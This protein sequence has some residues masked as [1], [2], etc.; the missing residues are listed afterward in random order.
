MLY[1]SLDAR[2]ID[3]QNTI[4]RAILLNLQY[5]NTSTPEEKQIYKDL[6]TNEELYSLKIIPLNVTKNS[7]IFGIT[8]NTSQNTMD[9]LKSRFLEK[10]ISFK[11][12]SESGFKEYMRLYDP[13]KAVT[14]NDINISSNEANIDAISA[15]LN[16]VRAE[17]M[18]AYLVQQS[19][20]LNASDIHLETSV[21][22]ARI[23]IRVHGVLHPIAKLNHE[24]YRQLIMALASAANISTSY[25]SDQTGHINRAYQMATGETIAVNLRVETVP[26]I[27]GIDAVLR[28][29]NFEPDRLNIRKLGMT[30]DQQNLVSNIISHPSGLVLIV[31][32]TGSG[33]TTTLYSILNEL[34]TPERK[35]ITLE[36]PVEYQIDGI[37][38][39]PV[40]SRSGE[41]FAEKFR[42]VMRLDPNVIMVG[43]IRDL[44]TAKTA[45]Q[46]ALTGH[47]VL[48]T[49]HADSA[50]AALT[51]ML[52]A[53][54]ENPLYAS[55]I[56]LVQAQRLVRTLDNQSKKPI[57]LDN[58]TANYIAKIVSEF[59]P[60][61][62]KFDP[63]ATTFYQPQPSPTNPFGFDGQIA[64][65]EFLLMDEP[66]QQLLRRPIQEI[67]TNEIKKTAM[68]S[69]MVTMLQD[70]IAKAA[71]GIT[72][73]EE[74]Y[75]VVD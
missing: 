40:N 2:Q 5:H 60:E 32:P 36:D 72:S 46:A 74:I 10:E 75:R 30:Q 24:K 14:Y 65:R 19:F 63:N 9:S 55:A 34:N 3:E 29:F 44:D 48:S 11:L 52:D 33:K 66:M 15:T 56:K 41:S 47:L 1:M 22:G 18:L 23:R 45:L 21:F 61:L 64:I 73:I 68:Q 4:K 7:I 25:D 17:D 16:Q 57:Q 39:I 35:I 43:E 54:G 31:G 51:R 26:A 6:L 42:A 38:Q 50:A 37:S 59:P 53:I 27:N 69:G 8:T 12:I 67:T 70:G 58:T 49:Y 62:N 28:L 13:P 20:R 71:E